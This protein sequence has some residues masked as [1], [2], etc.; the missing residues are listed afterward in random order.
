MMEAPGRREAPE[1]PVD[2]GPLGAVGATITSA[3]GQLITPRL[4]PHGVTL[5][6]FGILNF[7]F[8]GRA[9]TV[10]ELA[11]LI[12]IDI[13]S[14]SRQVDKLVKN[15]LLRRRRLQSDRRVVQLDL[16]DEGTALVQ[17]VTATVL[18]VNAILL[19]GVSPEERRCFMEVVGK[20]VANAERRATAD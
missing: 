20:I 8:R 11:D 3:Y 10:T 16:T 12:P 15:G 18:E 5:I 19:S 7:C 13:A 9:D 2:T 14:I 4:V 1:E 6:Q 17:A